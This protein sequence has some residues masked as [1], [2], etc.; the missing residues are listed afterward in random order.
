MGAGAGK[1]EISAS[2]KV[3]EKNQKEEMDEME[4]EETEFDDNALK[5]STPSMSYFFSKVNLMSLQKS[6][7]GDFFSELRKEDS[8]MFSNVSYQR[9]HPMG[10]GLSRAD[11][12]RPLPL[13]ITP[14]KDGWRLHTNYG[15]VYTSTSTNEIYNPLQSKA[16]Q[17]VIDKSLINKPIQTGSELRVPGDFLLLSKRQQKLTKMISDQ[18]IAVFCCK[19]NNPSNFS[20]RNILID[21]ALFYNSKIR[22]AVLTEG[23]GPFASEVLYSTND[24]CPA[25]V[26]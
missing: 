22:I 25:I 15:G 9:L 16:F 4:R 19:G 24:R 6:I 13:P 20:R 23:E 17:G 1:S 10:F 5:E 18:N 8:M 12:K 21:Y 3:L 26:A 11:F 2:S 7:Q 14:R